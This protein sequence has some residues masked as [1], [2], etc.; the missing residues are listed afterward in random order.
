MLL[1]PVMAKRHVQ[2]MF[3]LMIEPIEQFVARLEAPPDRAQLE[4]A[5]EMTALTL[6]VV[7]A[8][9]FGHQFG[10]LAQAMRRIV[11]RGLRAAENATRLL[12]VAAPPRWLIRAAAAAIHHSPMSRRLST[13]SNG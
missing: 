12:M 11:T 9:L 6:D 2:G 10:D 5:G 8:A 13:G 3:E 7:G 4:I 1:N